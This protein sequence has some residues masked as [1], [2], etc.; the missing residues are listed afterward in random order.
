MQFGADGNEV[1]YKTWDRYH[2]LPEKSNGQESDLI[3]TVNPAYLAVLAQVGNRESAL[4]VWFY[5]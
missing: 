2:F 5:Y 1:S 3:T 4:S